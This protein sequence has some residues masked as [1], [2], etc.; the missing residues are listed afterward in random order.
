[1]FGLP[2]FQN[3]SQ[4]NHE[5]QLS[6]MN[7]KSRGAK[8][9]GFFIYTLLVYVKQIQPVP[10]RTFNALTVTLTRNFLDGVVATPSVLSNPRAIAS[11]ITCKPTTL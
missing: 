3:D 10:E 1:M 7:K 4:K 11:Q 8:T 6:F 5:E 2:F 9:P